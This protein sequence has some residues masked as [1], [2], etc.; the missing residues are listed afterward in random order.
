MPHTRHNVRI[1]KQLHYVK[2]SI[3]FTLT[4]S[5]TKPDENKEKEKPAAAVSFLET[6]GKPNFNFANGYI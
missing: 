3:K 1:R 2:I 4:L 5:E 6:H